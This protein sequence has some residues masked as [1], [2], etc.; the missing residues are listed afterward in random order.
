TFMALLVAR[1]GTFVTGG[2]QILANLAALCYMMPMAL[3]VAGASLAAQAIGAQ[4]PRLAARTGSVTLALALAGA[5]LTAAIVYGGRQT[6]VGL[7]TSD[8]QVAT[9]ALAL[10]PILP[11]FHL[12]DAMQC[13]SSYLLRTYKV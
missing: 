9:V 5:L 6:I 11:L 3:G 10:L 8:A 13:V 1:E 7:Y 12:S 2:H 4:D